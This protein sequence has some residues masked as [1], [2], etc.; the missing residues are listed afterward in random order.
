MYINLPQV[1]SFHSFA[2]SALAFLVTLGKCV[3]FSGLYFER[4]S[5]TSWDRA[6]VCSL[7]ALLR[8]KLARRC[9]SKL[10]GGDDIST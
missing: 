6:L 5:S 2:M 8:L 3:V 4:L 10:D 9:P 1:L 7:H